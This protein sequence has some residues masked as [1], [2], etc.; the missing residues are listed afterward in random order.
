MRFT[1]KLANNLFFI[2]TPFTSHAIGSLEA[3]PDSCFRI[4]LLYRCQHLEEGG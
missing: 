1:M 2:G 4:H 3:E